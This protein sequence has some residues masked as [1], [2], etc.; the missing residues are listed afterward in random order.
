[1]TR[2]SDS[3]KTKMNS[4]IFERAVILSDFDGTFAFSRL[5]ELPSPQRDN[6]KAVEYFKSLGGH[7]SLSTGRLP[8]V[9]SRIMPFYR[10]VVNAP[11]I[12]GNGSLLFD[13]E[14]G[15]AIE[16]HPASREKCEMLL[17][18]VLDKF[19]PERWY[20]YG[21]R[22]QECSPPTDEQRAEP[23]RFKTNFIFKTDEQ[24]IVFRDY[25][26]KNYKSV[27]NAV[28]SFPNC[29]EVVDISA[30]KNFLVTAAVR[31]VAEK[32]GIPPEQSSVY[33]AGDYENDIGVLKASDMSFCPSN[34]LDEVKRVADH[35]LCHCSEGIIY[36]MLEYIEEN[37][38]KKIWV[39]NSI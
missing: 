28:R 33:A 37:E 18:D 5:G 11:I 22:G 10:S 34:T 29:C 17:D 23:F 19:H 2:Y 32:T 36:P 14:S 35:T 26:R 38:R 13:P 9:L 30:A 6:L 12:M 39:K 16:S 3:L 31:A 27:F 25:V 15:S 20:F 4:R 24:T 8:A 21:S 7:F 1:M